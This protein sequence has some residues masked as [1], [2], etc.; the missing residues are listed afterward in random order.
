MEAEVEVRG[1]G[2]AVDVEEMGGG[3][4][5]NAEFMSSPTPSSKVVK[6]VFE[7]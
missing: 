3:T 2:R 5:G 6:S 7:L 4:E 1:G